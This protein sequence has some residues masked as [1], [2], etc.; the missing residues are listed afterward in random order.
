MRTA[1]KPSR[2]PLPRQF[3]ICSSVI[4]RAVIEGRCPGSFRRKEKVMN[5]PLAKDSL[6]KVAPSPTNERGAALATSLLIMSALAAVSMTVLAV[7]T[8]EARI[9]GSDLKRTQTYYAA[10]AGIEK[11]TNDFSDLF[12]KS[13]NPGLVDINAVASHYP[14]ELVSDGFTFTKPDGSPNQSILLDPSGTSQNVNI[15]S[16][17][18]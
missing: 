18:F 16:G 2:L 1:S 4:M 9:A 17:P 12:T 7:V 8:H 13:S 10:A 5:K 15:S 14:S 11:M 3:V 6:I